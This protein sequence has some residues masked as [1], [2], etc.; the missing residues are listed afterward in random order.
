MASLRTLRPDKKQVTFFFA[1][2]IKTPEY[3]LQHEK[4]FLQGTHQVRV[5]EG[6][7]DLQKFD[8]INSKQNRQIRVFVTFQSFSL[9]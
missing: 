6:C 5:E 9:L 7:L 2:K 1:R 3:I 4:S 8:N